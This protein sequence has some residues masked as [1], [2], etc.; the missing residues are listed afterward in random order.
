MHLV[1]WIISRGLNTYFSIKKLE[2]LA[3]S[4]WWLFSPA[5]LRWDIS[6]RKKKGKKLSKE[7]RN[8][9]KIERLI[10]SCSESAF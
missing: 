5:L 3:K 8:R 1:L 9:N 10:A 2:S 7:E 6:G 4:K